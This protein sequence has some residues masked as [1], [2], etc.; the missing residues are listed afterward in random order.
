M[1][2]VH[3]LVSVELDTVTLPAATA[4]IEHERRVAIFD[5][6]EKNSFEPVG[7]PD[8]A[9]GGGRYRL[10]LS[11]QDNRLVFDIDG[12]GFTRTY[13]ISLTPL[14]G[15]LRDYLM[16][17]D[18]YYEALRGSSASQIESVDMGRR[19]LHNEGA[20]QLKTRLDGKIIVDHETARRL[21]TLLCALYRRG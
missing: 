13:A 15:V 3:K 8:D 18:S 21:F 16:I 11:L 17:C 9:E 19:G 5:L 1:S 2:G 6:V 4:E 12:G 7:A 10:K 20:E 14:K